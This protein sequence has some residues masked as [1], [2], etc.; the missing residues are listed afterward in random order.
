[1]LVKETKLSD[2][3]QISFGYPKVAVQRSFLFGKEISKNIASLHVLIANELV[4]HNTAENIADSGL[5]YS[6]L[7]KIF[8]RDGVDG[9]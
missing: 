2:S 6:H 1:M 5:N 9:F 4:K 8:K 7:H 3:L